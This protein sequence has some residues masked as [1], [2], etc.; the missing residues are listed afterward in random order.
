[1]DV[2]ASTRRSFVAALF[3]AGFAGSLGLPFPARAAPDAPLRL[4]ESPMRL[5]RILTRGPGDKG[6]AAI[7]VERWWDVR[8]ARQGRGAVVSGRQAGARVDAPPKLAE[9]ARI[10]QQRDASGMLP[11]MLSEAGTILTAPPAPGESDTVAAALRA[12]EGVIARQPRLS[13]DERE[14]LRFYLAEVHRAGSGL[15]DALPG[16][17][18]F[19]TGAPVD[20]S[21]TVS[22]PDGLSGQFSLHYL[23]LACPDAPWLARAERRVVTALAGASREAREVWTL[24]PLTP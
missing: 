23:A 5:R 17:L 6:S 12:A 24:E 3:A 14:R 18:L 9:L 16:D 21:E 8:F 19:P 2:S 11:L 20:R 22:L 7:T 10:E 4:P 15:L 13:G 1:M